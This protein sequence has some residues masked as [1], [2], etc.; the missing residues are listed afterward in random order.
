MPS[1]NVSLSVNS[2]VDTFTLVQTITDAQSR[3]VDATLAAAAVNTEFDVVLTRADIK[4]IVL[5]SVGGDLT[6]KTNSTG[7]PG[8]TV[9]M[10]AGQILFWCPS[11]TGIQ[12]FGTDPFPT[13]DVT[14]LYLSSTAGTSFKLRAIVN[15]LNG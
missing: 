14:K 1:Q 2:G 7:S 5:Q 12:A 10:T 13:A 6:I 4:A 8:D 15:A 11:G 9:T 3:G